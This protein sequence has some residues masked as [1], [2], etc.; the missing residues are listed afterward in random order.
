MEVYNRVKNGIFNVNDEHNFKPENKVTRTEA[1]IMINRMLGRN[2]HEESELLKIN[3]PFKDLNPAYFAYLDI[4]EAL[5][6]HE[7]EFLKQ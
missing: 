3:N 7:Y 6:T 1:V 4:I 2:P 5:V